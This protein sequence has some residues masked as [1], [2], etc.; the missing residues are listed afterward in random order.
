MRRK[1]ARP[2]WSSTATL[3]LNIVPLPAQA[4]VQSAPGLQ[5]SG[6]NAP[7]LRQAARRRERVSCAG[8]EDARHAVDVEEIRDRAAANRCRITR[9]VG[10]DDRLA[11]PRLRSGKHH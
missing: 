3:T 7:A 5:E 2:N 8:S 6:A 10:E 4:P 11:A 1:P 9:R